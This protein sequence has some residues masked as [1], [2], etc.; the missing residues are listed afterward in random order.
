MSKIGKTADEL[1]AERVARAERVFTSDQFRRWEN[2]ARADAEANIYRPPPPDD[3]LLAQ[4][5]YLQAY[6]RRQYKIAKAK[7]EANG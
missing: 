7:R 4:D 1:L 2:Q 5:V 3:L 6:N